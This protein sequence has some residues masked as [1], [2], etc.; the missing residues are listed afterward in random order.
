MKEIFTMIV[1]NIKDVLVH[2]F[3]EIKVIIAAFRKP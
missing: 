2:T 1:K 3:L